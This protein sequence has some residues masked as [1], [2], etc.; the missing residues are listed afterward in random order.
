[1][2][3]DL[4]PDRNLENIRVA[5]GQDSGTVEAKAH[6]CWS[7]YLR[8]VHVRK[9]PSVKHLAHINARDSRHQETRVQSPV[10]G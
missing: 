5:A 7:E 3:I 6:S 2:M 1:M 8:D 10:A 4:T 9:R